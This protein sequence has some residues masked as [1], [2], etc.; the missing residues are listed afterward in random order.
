MDIDRDVN[1]VRLDLPHPMRG[2]LLTVLLAPVFVGGAALAVTGLL[3]TVVSGWMPS[4]WFSGNA[5]DWLVGTGVQGD[6]VNYVRVMVGGMAAAASGAAIRWGFV[7][8][9]GNQP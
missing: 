6:A 5:A 1:W 8:H 3:S 9:D 4:S 7:G 2:A